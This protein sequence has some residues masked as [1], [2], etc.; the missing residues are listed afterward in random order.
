MSRLTL[1]DADKQ[2]RDWFVETTQSLGCKVTIDAMGKS[3]GLKLDKHETNIYRKHLCCPSWKEKGASHLC[4]LT[5]GYT[6]KRQNGKI[7]T[8]PLEDLHYCRITKCFMQVCLLL[9][10]RVVD[11]LPSVLN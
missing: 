8:V 10:I 4:W 6:G 2:A 3:E 11:I 7:H 1:T 5:S 9:M